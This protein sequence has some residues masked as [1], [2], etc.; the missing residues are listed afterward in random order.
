MYAQIVHSIS[1]N[2]ICDSLHHHESV[3]GTLR[4]ASAPEFRTFINPK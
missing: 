4:G 1:L 3:L 2:D